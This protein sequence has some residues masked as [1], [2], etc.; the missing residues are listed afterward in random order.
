MPAWPYWL[1]LC[2]WLSSSVRNSAHQQIPPVRALGYRYV[3]VRHR[4]RV[5]ATGAESPPWRL[6]GAVDG[7]QLVWS[8]S[9]PAG[10]PT[11]LNKGQLAE[12]NAT[13][14][15]A[16]ESQDASHP[17]YFA[18]YMT[19]GD[20]LSGEGDPEFVH[21]VPA[22]QYLRRS[23]RTVGWFV[24]TSNASQDSDL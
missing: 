4:N 9:T 6:V 5:N 15:F 1:S 2:Y 24:P 22:E 14:P 3:G 19:G 20:P 12:F 10:A 13:G 11:T 7:T 21:I 17:F 8:P 23:R 16:V 18:Q